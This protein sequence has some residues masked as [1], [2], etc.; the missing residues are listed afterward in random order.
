MTAVTPS[1]GTRAP[2][3]PSATAPR[4]AEATPGWAGVVVRTAGRDQACEWVRENVA[5]HDLVLVKASRGAALEVVAE[6]L[7]DRAP[8]VPGS[9]PE[10]PDDPEVNTEVQQR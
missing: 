7:L 4:G 3:D 2:S 8:T 6:C 5:A 9:P 10:N 1:P